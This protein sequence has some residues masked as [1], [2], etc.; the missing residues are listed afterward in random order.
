MTKNERRPR[1]GECEDLRIQLTHASVTLYRQSRAHA[2]MGEAAVEF[3]EAEAAEELDDVLREA[4]VTYSNGETM[5]VRARV[6]RLEIEAESELI[7]VSPTHVRCI[8]VRARRLDTGRRGSGQG[9]G[10]RKIYSIGTPRTRIGFLRA[11]P[12][13]KIQWRAVAE[14][15]GAP[16]PP[17]GPL[18][19]DLREL[20]R[21]ENGNPGL[22]EWLA[23]Y[24]VMS[25]E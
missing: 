24:G 18:P 16:A 1:L 12:S 21:D 8:F 22:A 19:P 6:R 25:D 5:R 2:S 17:W 15:S 4:Y 9:P 23:K 7:R 14:T 3:T 11:L 20:A 13:G 10:T